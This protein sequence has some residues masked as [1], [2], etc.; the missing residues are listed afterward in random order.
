MIELLFGA[1]SGAL[2]PDSKE[3]QEHAERYYNLVRRMRTDVQKI[4]QNTGYPEQEIAQIKRFIFLEEHDLGDGKIER[5][6]ACYEMAASWQR[7]IDGK[8]IQKHDLTLLRHELM[9]HGLMLN[10]MSQHDAHIQTSRVYNYAL[11][12]ENYYDSIKKH[13]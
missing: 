4:A 3:A 6:A 2:D 7:L 13:S 10:G 8:D 9:E 5:F 11:E 12:A 1:I